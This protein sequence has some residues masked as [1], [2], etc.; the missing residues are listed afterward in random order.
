MRCVPCP[1]CLQNVT[2]VC[3]WP[4]EVVLG[5][6]VSW[7]WNKGWCVFVPCNL[8]VPNGH[9]VSLSLVHHGTV[10]TCPWWSVCYGICCLEVE[11]MLSCCLPYGHMTKVL[12]TYL[13]HRLGFTGEDCSACHSNSWMKRLAT[14]SYEYK[15]VRSFVASPGQ[16]Q[17]IAAC[18]K[19]TVPLSV[20]YRPVGYAVVKTALPA[21]PHFCEVLQLHWQSS[22]KLS[23]MHYMEES[24]LKVTR[25]RPEGWV[26]S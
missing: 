22:S 26:V 13:S 15:Q 18:S 12:S 14:S 2:S 9:C 11:K 10:D 3:W 5:D 17:Y 19:G 8:C 7:R 25:Q 6:G 24:P 4:S 23:L 1:L 20:T 21:S 16:T